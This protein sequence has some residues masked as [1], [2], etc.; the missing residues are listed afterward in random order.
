MNNLKTEPM[1]K[2]SNQV[3]ATTDYAR[4]K[5]LVGNRKPND[6][7]VKRLSNSFQKRY[8]FSPIL[9]NEKW[10]IID[11][12]HRFLA[13]K[14][15]GLPINYI[16]VDGYGLNEVQILNTNSANWKKEDY[17]K[18]YCDLGVSPYL[19][20][21]QFMQDY[22]D[23]GIA[24]SEQLI[25]NT[26]GGVNNRDKICKGRGRVKNFEE[27]RLTIPDLKQSYDNAEKVLMFKRYYD[28]FNR[29]VFV[30]ALIGIFQNENYNHAEMIGKLAQQPSS[31]THC[32]NVTQ[33]KVLIEEIY[34]H[35]RR[36]KV[37]LRY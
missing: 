15:L 11:G 23:F 32:T 16:I 5:T 24:V 26:T 12:Q 29:S 3:Q 9:I 17:L 25:T 36:D 18:A 14:E 4:F 7:H 33:Y 34:N 2:N 27:G 37:N 20:M 31:L 28:G 8:L 22:P 30:S 35:R 19:Q 13:A 21:K 10:Q 1:V 6:L